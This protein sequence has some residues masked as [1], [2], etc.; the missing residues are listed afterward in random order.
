METFLAPTVHPITNLGYILTRHHPS[1]ALAP[2]YSLKVL[3]H[4]MLPHAQ[5]QE[6][7]LLVDPMEAANTSIRFASNLKLGSKSSIFQLI[8]HNGTARQTN[9]QEPNLQVPKEITLPNG[10]LSF[11]I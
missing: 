11:S 1:R 4:Q 10:Q 7:V 9:W 6:Q 2:I 3:S 5:H 8:L